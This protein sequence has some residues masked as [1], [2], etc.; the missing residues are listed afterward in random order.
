M[1]CKQTLRIYW[2]APLHH[3]SLFRDLSLP[4]EP[5]SSGLSFHTNTIISLS[6]PKPLSQHPISTPSLGFSSPHRGQRVFS[7]VSRPSPP[8]AMSLRWL[9]TAFRGVT[10]GMDFSGM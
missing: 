7:K 5:Q 3:T 4:P 10:F 2:G 1:T 8:Y 6:T 9:P